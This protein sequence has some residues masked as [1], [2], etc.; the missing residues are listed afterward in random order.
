MKPVKSEGATN[1]YMEWVVLHELGHNVHDFHETEAYDEYDKNMMIHSVDEGDLE[2]HLDEGNAAKL[3]DGEVG[4]RVEAYGF[5]YVKQEGGSVKKFPSSLYEES[6]ADPET[7]EYFAEHYNQ[8]I[9]APEA[10]AK[11][12]LDDPKARL[13][14]ADKDLEQADKDRKALVDSGGDTTEIDAR[15]EEIKEEQRHARV[16]KKVWAKQYDVMRDKVFHADDAE[17]SARER[18]VEGG[19]DTSEFD[20]RVG[21]LSTPEQIAALEAELRAKQDNP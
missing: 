8:A 15:I 14:K 10:T 5:T 16:N 21:R 7:G 11:E 4:T 20:E 17:L 1:T 18:L 12:Y 13:D 19:Y 9:L 6:D 2:T 3:K